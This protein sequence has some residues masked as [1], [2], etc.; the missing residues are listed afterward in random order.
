MVNTRFQKM[1][2]DSTEED[3]RSFD[4]SGKS[5]VLIGSGV[6]GAERFIAYSVSQ[7]KE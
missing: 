5:I 7:A 2:R 1:T 3:R 6:G 4:G